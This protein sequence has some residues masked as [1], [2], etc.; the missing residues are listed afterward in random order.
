MDVEDTINEA[1]G[2]IDCDDREIWVNC[3]MAIKDELG[4]DGFD[5]WNNWSMSAPSYK[6]SSALS[7]WN[8][9]SPGGITKGT[10]YFYAKEGGWE[11]GKLPPPPKKTSKIKPEGPSEEDYAEVAE[12][13]DSIYKIAT[14]RA[15]PYLANK[16]FPNTKLPSAWGKILLPVRT[17]GDGKIQTLQFICPDG[18][19]YFMS[20]G[21]VKGGYLLWS[22]NGAKE[23]WFVEG[24]ATA[25]SVR[26]AVAQK[27]NMVICFSALKIPEVVKDYS[28]PGPK[29]L[30][31]DRD[32]RGTGEKYAIQAD[33]PWWAPPEIG[34]ANDFHL[35]HGID[36]L[37]K[38]LNTFVGSTY[39]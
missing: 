36:A 39:F 34:D 4:S 30:V 28:R 24:L 32:E 1:L 18:A 22:V 9:I 26:Q 14:L 12:K 15:N 38:E 17:H 29:F 23:T 27:V 35:A 21:K 37:T 10:L 2:F 19:K 6:P 31:A 16:G 25:L 5:I 8:S 11:P 13:A 3:A 7:V 20:G 33:I